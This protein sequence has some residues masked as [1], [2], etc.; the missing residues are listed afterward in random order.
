MR[1]RRARCGGGRRPRSSRSPVARRAWRSRPPCP[2]S[3][4]APS[5][6]GQLHLPTLRHERSED[7]VGHRNGLPR[8]PLDWRRADHACPAEHREL[9]PRHVARG[10]R[11]GPCGREMFDAIAPRYDL[12]NRVMTFRLDVRWRRRTVDALALPAGSRRAR[13][14]Q[15]HRRPVRRP[16]RRRPAPRSRSTSPSAC[17]PPIAAARRVV[18]ADVLRLPVRRRHRRRRHVRLRPAQPRRAAGVLRRA[19]PRGAPRGTH[20]TA[21]RRRAPQPAGAPRPRH[22]LRTHRAS[23]RR[24]GCRIRRRT[25]TC[26]AA[27]PT[28]R[29]RTR[30]SCSCVAPGSATRRTGC[31]RS[32]WPSCSPAR[33]A[34]LPDRPDAGRHSARRRRHPRPRPQRRRARRRVPV[35][36]G[37]RRVR[38]ARRRGAG[39]RRRRA[40]GARSDRPRRRDRFDGARR[41]RP[42]RPRMRCRS[43]PAAP[44]SSSCPAVVVGKGADGSCWVT[45]H[46]RTTR[47]GDW[48]RRPAAPP[49]TADVVTRRAGHARRAVPRRRRRGTRRR[50]RRTDRQ[51]RDRPRDRWS[52]GDADRPPR[53][54]A[55]AAGRVRLELPL[56]RRRLRRR[57]AG[58]AGGRRRATPCASHPLAG[59][60]P[61]RRRPRH[62]AASPPSSSPAPRTRSSTGSY[63][64]GARHAA[65][66]VQLP[67]LGARAVDRPRG[68]RA[69]PGDAHRGPA[70]GAAR[71]PW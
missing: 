37:R 44:A 56:S 39:R 54:A 52:P 21:R 18:Q 38:R 45:T 40:G 71:R 25:A 15:R 4:A 2:T 34:L 12:V 47:R 63:R 13:P 24:A 28:C 29:R 65:A 48:R 5:I 69:A 30:W 42:G 14:R 1:R 11:E 6:A 66:V 10:R 19:R 20:R 61:R 64:H 32:A 26:H 3:P 50:A 53:R 35:R 8:P 68:Q 67:R 70:L 60:A 9:E 49:P 36:P 33:A 27:S 55:P 23:R 59:T 22:L 46:R 16:R 31:S 41:R 17:S 57:L 7:H 51:G 43:P 58:A 62:D